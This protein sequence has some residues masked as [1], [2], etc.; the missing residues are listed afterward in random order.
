MIYLFQKSACKAKKLALA[1]GKGRT[2]LSDTSIKLT[3]KL[4]DIVFEVSLK[5]IDLSLRSVK[6]R[7]R[8][9]IYLL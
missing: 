2:S 3:R 9:E 8:T 5:G 7:R 4:Q 6:V 1:T